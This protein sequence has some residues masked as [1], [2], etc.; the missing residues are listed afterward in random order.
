MKKALSFFTSTINKNRMSHLYLLEG[1]KGAGKL[2][3]SFLVSTDLL[4][5]KGDDKD[6]LFEQVRNLR[7]PNVMLIKPD[8]LTI[9]KEQILILQ[10]EFS[11]TSLVEGARIYIIDEVEKMT[12]AAAN[13]LLKFMEEPEGKKTYGFLLTENINSVLQTIQSRS[14][15]I[16][17]Q[18]IDKKEIKNKLLESDID[19]L[20]AEILPEITNNTDEALEL[21][22]NVAVFEIHEFISIMSE[23]WLNSDSI[24]ALDLAD[25]MSQTKADRMWYS[26]FSNLLLLFF[27]DVIRYK[28]HRSLTFESLRSDIQKISG[29]YSLLELEMIT[30]KLETNI[31]RQKTFVNIDLYYQKLLQELDGERKRNDS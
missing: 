29:K 25:K 31:N 10:N 23:N 19:P 8:G 20:L 5:R 24:F 16:H 14:Q 9:K 13:S 18:G 15:I 22:N 26:S 17:L 28:V 1:P 4:C 3:L 12:S 7:H 2:S 30:S 11:K 21:V 27:T 6:R